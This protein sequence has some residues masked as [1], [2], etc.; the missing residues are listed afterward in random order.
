MAQSAKLTA[1]TVSM[2]MFTEGTCVVSIS[3]LRCIA[4]QFLFHFCELIFHSLCE[5]QH[6]VWDTAPQSTKWRDILEISTAPFH[7]CHLL[8]IA[9]LKSK[10][11]CILFIN[12]VVPVIL[13]V[14][15]FSYLM[16]MPIK[17]FSPGQ[18][19]P[20]SKQCLRSKLSAGQICCLARDISLFQNG[21]TN[22]VVPQ[23]WV[24]SIP[25]W[26]VYFQRYRC[27][28]TNTYIWGLNSQIFGWLAIVT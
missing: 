25:T 3:E 13:K 22:S 14:T 7:E 8:F 6:F 4:H 23:E 11:W 27:L 10:L 19:F 28:I 1:M 20:V 18:N 17:L 16:W 26:G 24:A 21:F 9:L 2:T 12:E 15:S 5:Q